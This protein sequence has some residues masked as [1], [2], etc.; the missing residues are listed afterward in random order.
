M[1]AVVRYNSLSSSVGLDS[2]TRGSW[3][4]V[5]VFQELLVC[6]ERFRILALESLTVPSPHCHSGGSPGKGSTLLS[7]TR[8]P[9]CW[10]VK[11]RE[12]H[13]TVGVRSRT[14]SPD[15]KVGL[16]SVPYIWSFQSMHISFVPLGICPILL[17]QGQVEDTTVKAQPRPLLSLLEG[18][19]FP[20]QENPTGAVISEMPNVWP[21]KTRMSQLYPGS[22][23]DP[24]DYGA[25]F[26]SLEQ[27][28]LASTLWYP[29]S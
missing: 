11:P 10:G 25:S 17:C 28:W 8:K 13:C 4:I 12:W 9:W 20:W 6:G 16:F 1:N 27:D 7:D 18:P 19:F 23:A 29:S 22:Q 15:L 2:T 21:L 5:A 14:R 3:R 24:G 26:R